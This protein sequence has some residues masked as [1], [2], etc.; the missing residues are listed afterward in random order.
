M[1]DLVAEKMYKLFR[2]AYYLALSERPFTDYPKIIELQ[3]LN[4]IELGETCQND[5]ATKEFISQIAGYFADELKNCI[6]SLPFISIYSDGSTD[7]SE[8][9][10]EIVMVKVLDYFYPVIKYLKIEEPENT[11]AEGILAAINKAFEDVGVQ[12]SGVLL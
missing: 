3:N 6:E 4:G 2:T 7:R 9:E 12:D 11:K 5:K 1:V 8:K 10:K